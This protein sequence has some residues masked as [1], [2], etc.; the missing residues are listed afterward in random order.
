MED[1]TFW[2]VTIIGIV[3]FALFVGAF[4]VP[5]MKVWWAEQSGRAEL[6]QAEQNRNIAVVE[7]T[8]KRDAAIQL[9]EAEINRAKGVAEANRIIGDSLRGNEEYLRY[10]WLVD[11]AGSN[12]GKTIVYVPTETNLPILEATRLGK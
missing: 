12:V 11:V 4:M 9:A 8:A 3:L 7:A 5:L 2:M 1:E 10:L 6:A